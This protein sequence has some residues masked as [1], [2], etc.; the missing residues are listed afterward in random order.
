MEGK[1]Q[2]EKHEHSR[3]SLRRILY[4]ESIAWCSAFFF[5]NCQ[6]HHIP[7]HWF[8][9]PLRHG[10]HPIHLLW[11]WDESRRMETIASATLLINTSPLLVRSSHLMITASD[12]VAT[13]AKK[14]RNSKSSLL[15]YNTQRYS[16]LPDNEFCNIEYISIY[17]S[18]GWEG[19]MGGR[20]ARLGY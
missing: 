13:K 17:S 16:G 2:N 14:S 15:V 20:S 10:I 5:A 6:Y 4:Y 18:I 12:R 1:W 8:I 9:P 7:F 3:R 11:N 19:L